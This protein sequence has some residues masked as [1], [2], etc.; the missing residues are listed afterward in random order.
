VAFI[1][2]LAHTQLA[3]LHA[4]QVSAEARQPRS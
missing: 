2:Q 3:A 4:M 1:E